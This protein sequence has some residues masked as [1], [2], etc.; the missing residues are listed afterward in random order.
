[1]EMSKNL[2]IYVLS[3]SL[4]FVGII[5]ANQAEGATSTASQIATLQKQVKTLDSELRASIS[6]SQFTQMK[7]ENRTSVLEEIVGLDT[8]FGITTSKVQKIYECVRLLNSGR[9]CSL[10]F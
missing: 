6:L 1:M 10:T 9:Q 5:S 7:L 8:S 2:P 3:A 4:V